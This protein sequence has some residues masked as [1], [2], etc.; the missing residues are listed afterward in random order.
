MAYYS[1]SSSTRCPGCPGDF[2]PIPGC[3]KDPSRLLFI[4]ER[5]GK[6]EQERLRIA[7]G[8]TGEEMDYTYLPL[9]HL[10]RADVRIE[11]T[12]RCWAL[13]N[14]Q[15]SDKEVQSCAN[16]FLPSVLKKCKPEVVVL[17]GGTA[18]KIIDSPANAKRPRVDLLHG[19]PF[20][21]SILNGVWEGWIWSSYHP[22]LGIHDTT[23]MTYLM[24]DFQHL[25]EW[26]EGDWQPPTPDEGVEKDY[27]IITNVTSLSS[28][29]RDGRE[30]QLGRGAVDRECA[31]ARAIQLAVDTERHGPDPWSVQLSLRPNTGRLI[32]YRRGDSADA[33]LLAEFNSFIR[34]TGAEVSLHNAGQDLDMLESMGVWTPLFRDT[35]SEAF[36]LC[37]F[38]QGLKA[39]VFRTIGARMTSWEDVVWPASIDL[40]SEWVAGAINLSADHLQ[41]VDVEYMKTFTCAAC[42]HRAHPDVVCK[43]KAGGRTE[44]CGCESGEKYSNEKTIAKSGAIEKILRHVLRYT[45]ETEMS[46]D[47]YDPWVALVGTA[48]KPGMLTKGLRGD[49][50]EKWEWEW[51]QDVLGPVP[52]LGIGN[53]E[54]EAAVA[55]GC[56]DADYTGQVADVLDQERRDKR[57]DVVE[58]D[59][60]K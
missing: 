23:K 8:K 20:Y 5:P 52:V 60:D 44:K 13:G 57:W 22:A 7:I 58:E 19:R 55:Y 38:P 53:C 12:V 36:E 50:P 40:M 41:H 14:R 54:L 1:S 17:M 43:S 48:K 10:R 26:L 46:D 45:L 24:D 34:E 15:P 18:H 35:M 39:L 16:H 37:A 9:A 42:G 56:S 25:G 29:L 11:N 32:R 30:Y 31:S 33:R 21:G 59:W 2:T 3:G 47:P 4:G 28:Y 49:I 51:L 6:Q 27:G